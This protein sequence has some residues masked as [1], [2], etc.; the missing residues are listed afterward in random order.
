MLPVAATGR[1]GPVRRPIRRGERDGV[2]V[3]EVRVVMDGYARR[4]ACVCW[5]AAPSTIGDR[6]DAPPVVVVNDTLAARLWPGRPLQEVVGQQVRASA[7]DVGGVL[8]R[9]SASSQACARGAPMCRR[10]P[11]FTLLSPSRR[12]ASLSYVVRA[13]GDPARL[14]PS[15]SRRARRDDA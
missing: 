10:I 9:S 12:C 2:P 1:N 4:W 14:T 6:A 15:D 8:R 7:L 3:T 11:K 13:E 5:P